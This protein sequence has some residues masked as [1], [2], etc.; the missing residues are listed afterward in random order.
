MA[1]D[2]ERSPREGGDC[3]AS[4]CECA[5]GV[6]VVPGGPVS[7]FRP[8]SREVIENELERW[9]GVIERL[10]NVDDTM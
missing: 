7:V 6:P 10:G 5:R 3:D 2:E 1:V 9:R 4:D 8:V